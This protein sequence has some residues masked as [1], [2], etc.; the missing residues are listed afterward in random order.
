MNL[1]DDARLYDLQYE[2]YRDDVPHY[3][4]LAAQE[5]GPVLELGSGTGRLTA[6]LAGAGFR[7][8]GV[9]LAAGMLEVARERL[10]DTALLLQGDMRRLDGLDLEPG[11]FSLVIAPFNALM[12]LHGLSDQDAALA[13]AFRLLRPGGLLALDL[14]R[15]DPGPLGVLRVEPEW[16]HVAGEGGQLFLVQEHDEL[17]Q[18]ITSR[19]LIDEQTTGGMFRRRTVTLTQRYYHRFEIERALLAAGF[20]Q[21]RLSGSFDGSRY[22]PASTHM[23]ITC[24]RPAAAR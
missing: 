16:S 7:V 5:D 21:F 18:V 4:R 6:A 9:E 11:S 3:L 17:N 2:R 19:Y 1:Y 15:P 22:T 20:G 24:R 12:H 23:V 14:Y 8:T 10:G 13:G